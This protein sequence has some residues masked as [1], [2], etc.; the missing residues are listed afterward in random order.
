YSW[1]LQISM[2]AIAAVPAQ[3]ARFGWYV[4]GLACTVAA[5]AL[6]WRAFRATTDMVRFKHLGA[7]HIL[8]CYLPVMCMAAASGGWPFGVATMVAMAG[9]MLGNAS[10]L[11]S[12]RVVPALVLGAPGHQRSP[13]LSPPGRR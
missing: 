2:G 10:F 9:P 12:F 3:P 5:L 1:A 4:V 7:A 13:E 8:V 6:C 11:A